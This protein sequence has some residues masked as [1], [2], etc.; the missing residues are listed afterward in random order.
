[1]EEEK[2]DP[3]DWEI[4]KTGIRARETAMEFALKINVDSLN[5]NE[6]KKI[7]EDAQ[8]IADFLLNIEQDD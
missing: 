2:I 5:A 7:I 3:M 8:L 1:M 6:T 4:E